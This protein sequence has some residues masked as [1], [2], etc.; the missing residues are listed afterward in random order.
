MKMGLGKSKKPAKYP[1]DQND[2]ELRIANDAK[3]FHSYEMIRKGS[4]RRERALQQ[5]KGEK[6]TSDP[7]MRSAYR[8]N[9]EK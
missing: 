4:L 6:S 1:Q 2:Q 8:M 9:L 3:A 7:S 5:C